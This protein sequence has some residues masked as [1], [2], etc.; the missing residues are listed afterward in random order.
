MS[1]IHACGSGRMVVS[2]LASWKVCAKGD[3]SGAEG[4][5]IGTEE[6]A[7]Y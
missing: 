1:R 3:L 5:C 2:Y 7:Q 6:L 4:T